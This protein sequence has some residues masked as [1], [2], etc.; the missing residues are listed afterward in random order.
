MGKRFPTREYAL[1][2]GVDYLGGAEGLQEAVR[3]RMGNGGRGV[4]D[5]AAKMMVGLGTV[6]PSGVWS[7]AD[8]DAARNA[9]AEAHV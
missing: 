1:Q 8:W 6:S 2:E 5:A 9:V 7:I 3:E 4:T